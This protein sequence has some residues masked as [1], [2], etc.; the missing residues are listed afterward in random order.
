MRNTVLRFFS[1]LFSYSVEKGDFNRHHSGEKF[2][3][4][5]PRRVCTPAKLL[6]GCAD[7]VEGGVVSVPKKGGKNQDANERDAAARLYY[8]QYLT[9]CD[10]NSQPVMRDSKT[11][12]RSHRLTGVSN[13]RV[14]LA[15]C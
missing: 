11:E 4:A 9:C 2:D 5:D 14:F 6:V 3:D 10:V 7:S 15:V 13:P 1:F 12:F 8:F